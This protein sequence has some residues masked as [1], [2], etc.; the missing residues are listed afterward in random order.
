MNKN[1]NSKG[2]IPCKKGESS[3]FRAK[4]KHP[5]GLNTLKTAVTEK[6]TI[7]KARQIVRTLL[8]GFNT[9][10]N[11][12]IDITRI[13]LFIELVKMLKDTNFEVNHNTVNNTLNT[14]IPISDSLLKAAESF[15]SGVV[16]AEEVSTPIPISPDNPFLISAKEIQRQVEIE[17]QITSSL[18]Q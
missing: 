17:T 7:T 9:D 3:Y 8:K 13:K 6:L 18:L 5:R 12:N 1:P 11:G 15:Y 2:L 4:K 10:E 16:E 14:N